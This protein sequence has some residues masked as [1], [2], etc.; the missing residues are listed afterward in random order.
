MKYR[1]TH[2]HRNPK[3]LILAALAR[4][5]GNPGWMW[6]TVRKYPL[7]TSPR[8][9]GRC[10]PDIPSL[11]GMTIYCFRNGYQLRRRQSNIGNRLAFKFLRPEFRVLVEI[12]LNIDRRKLAPDIP[13][14][15]GRRYD[16]CNGLV[17][18][19]ADLIYIQLCLLRVG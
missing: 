15:T 7:T 3:L 2:R 19:S 5:Q 8:R 4:G 12:F 17:I 9:S 13:P 1:T 10:H 18:S 6:K 14:G 16:G 11:A